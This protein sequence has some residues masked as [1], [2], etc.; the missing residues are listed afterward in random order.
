M[1]DYLFF[2]PIAIALGIGVISP[3][4]SFLYVAQTAMNK[5]RAHGI[6]TSLGMGT[7]SLLLALMA[8]LGLFVILQT[9]PVLYIALKTIGGL[10][11]FYIAYNMWKGADDAVTS[12]SQNISPLSNHKETKGN[13]NK[14]P[15]GSY[16]KSYL[17]G[18]L[19]QLS[20][21]KTA[22]VIGGIFMAFLPAQVPDYSTPLLSLMAFIIDAIWYMIVSIALTTARAQRIYLRFKKHINR[23]ASGLMALLGLK[24]AFNQ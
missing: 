9:V 6:A 12:S 18:L 16:Y 24:L 3:G 2:I 20:N 14:D 4:P 1:N 8:I 17:L 22:I 10:Y 23:L 21:P 11:L 19:T 13:D 5:S 7:G 15:H